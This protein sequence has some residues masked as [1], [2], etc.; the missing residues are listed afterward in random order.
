MKTAE[1]QICIF[2]LYFSIL[3]TMQQGNVKKQSA[4]PFKGFALFD[5]NYLYNQSRTPCSQ[6]DAMIGGFM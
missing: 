5:K 4:E 6:S 3:L 1:R 2:R